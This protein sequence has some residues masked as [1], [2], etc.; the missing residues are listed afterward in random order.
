MAIFLLGALSFLIFIRNELQLIFHKK[1]KEIDQK[2]IDQTVKDLVESYSYIGEVNRKMDILMNVALGISNRS[3]L[4]KKKEI[5]IY[6]SIVS[7]TNFLMKA[8]GTILRFVNLSNKAT[9][10]EIRTPGHQLSV[11]NDELVSV[12]DGVFTKKN[13]GHIIIA[14][15]QKI[16]DTRSFL[17]I[18][19]YDDEEENNPKNIEILKVFAS[20]AIFLYSYVNMDELDCNCET[21]NN[22][23]ANKK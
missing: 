3:M 23:T 6:D 5:D 11:K 19:G 10:K 14:S 22:K 15:A 21:E 18:D 4:N 13:D 2:K 9:A 7:A 12:N 1:E 20:Q 8:E 17:I 16:N